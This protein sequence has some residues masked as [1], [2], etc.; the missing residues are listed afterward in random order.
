MAQVLAR[1]YNSLLCAAIFYII[2]YS[3][4]ILVF[5]LIC[6]FKNNIRVLLLF[7]M[8]LILTINLFFILFHLWL[9]LF[10]ND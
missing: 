5:N 3:L 2:T 9:V 10:A 8:Q 1:L 4:K 6:H 7:G